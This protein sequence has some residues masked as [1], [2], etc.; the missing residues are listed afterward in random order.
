[1]SQ[2]NQLLQPRTSIRLHPLPARDRPVTS[3]H[4]PNSYNPNIRLR[5]AQILDLEPPR[6]QRHLRRLHR[7]PPHHPREP[8]E[9]DHEERP[10]DGHGEGGDAVWATGAEEAQTGRF[11]GLCD[12]MEA[13]EGQG[14]GVDGKR[15]EDAS[16]G[17]VG[18]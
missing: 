17:V 2:L 16:V 12:G 6:A 10:L 8:R 3:A 18:E 1:M 13:V 11:Q 15:F 9:R 4:P 14:C 5:R 7:E